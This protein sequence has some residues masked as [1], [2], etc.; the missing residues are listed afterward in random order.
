MSTVYSVCSHIRE[1]EIVRAHVELFL[2]SS[3]SSFPKQVLAS[4]AFY[5]V[6]YSYT[7]FTRL[8]MS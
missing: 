7:C 5:G 3:L 6:Q 8:V 4:S 1:K 2:E